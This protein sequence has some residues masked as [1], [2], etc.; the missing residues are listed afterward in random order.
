VIPETTWTRQELDERVMQIRSTGLVPI[1]RFVNEHAPEVFSAGMAAAPAVAEEVA[2]RG[3]RYA[4]KRFARASARVLRKSILAA[5]KEMAEQVWRNYPELRRG[6][7]RGEVVVP[8]ISE[9]EAREIAIKGFTKFAETMI[10]ETVG[11]WVADAFENDPDM[12]RRFL[13]H[14]VGREITEAFSTRLL[15]AFADATIRTY[16]QQSTN[17]MQLA[18]TLWGAWG[19]QLKDSI[20]DALLNVAG[21]AAR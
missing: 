16:V 6:A 1:Y 9:A 18:E 4:L 21:V 13:T 19:E 12:Q 11:S 3:I 15:Q 10:K 14:T 8:Q 5:V 20:E 2:E 17:E 7:G